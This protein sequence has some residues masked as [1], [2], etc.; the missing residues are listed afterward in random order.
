MFNAINIKA[1]LYRHTH[2]Y[3]KSV[4]ENVCNKYMYYYMPKDMKNMYCNCIN[5]YFIFCYK[6][7]NGLCNICCFSQVQ[8][9]T[10]LYP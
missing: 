7:I 9:L 2:V 5:T 1:I 3:V 6:K 8:Y 4:Y 10:V